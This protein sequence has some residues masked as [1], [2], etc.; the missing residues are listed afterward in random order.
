MNEI[1]TS[2]MKLEKFAEIVEKFIPARVED[3]VVEA[4]PA[5]DGKF[6]AAV[7]VVVKTGVHQAFGGNVT[8]RLKYARLPGEYATIIGKDAVDVDVIGLKD[9]LDHV[10]EEAA[11]FDVEIHTVMAVGG[12]MANIDKI[13]RE[14]LVLFRKKMSD[15][16]YR[17]RKNGAEEI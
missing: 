10:R 3:T 17:A 13:E 4:K 12:I 7:D 9:S 6:D 8:L 5:P 14:A 15:Y 11:K 1:T 16:R 2:S